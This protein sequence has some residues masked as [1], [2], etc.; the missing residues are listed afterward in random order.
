[1]SMVWVVEGP[2]EPEHAGDV[3]D[4]DADVDVAAADVASVGDGAAV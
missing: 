3:A 1:M 2:A 4:A